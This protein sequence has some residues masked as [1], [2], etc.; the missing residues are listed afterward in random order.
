MNKYQEALDR[1][2][3]TYYNLDN[4]LSAM[5]RFGKDI[6]TLSELVDKATPKKVQ[7]IDTQRKM[8]RK[9]FGKQARY[10]GVCPTCKKG[11]YPHYNY[12]SNCGQRLEWGD[13]DE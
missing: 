7:F 3:E 2:E 10:D 5:K 13:E 1:V 9:K 12:C 4:C 6:Q 8:Y 11:V